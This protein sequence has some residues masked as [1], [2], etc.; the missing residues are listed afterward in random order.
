MNSGDCGILEQAVW[1]AGYDDVM[2]QVV[3]HV[4]SVRGLHMAS[5]DDP[6]R[7]RHGRLVG[8]RAR[9]QLLLCIGDNY[10]CAWLMMDIQPPGGVSSLL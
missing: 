10:S 3:L 1:N 6:G 7:E 9:C 8:Q 2:S 5:C 4:L